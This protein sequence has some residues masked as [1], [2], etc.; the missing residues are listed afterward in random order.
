VLVRAAVEDAAGSTSHA[1]KHALKKTGHATKHVARST[2]D[3][4]DDAATVSEDSGANTFNVLVN[5]TDADGDSL[6]VTGVT[7]GTHG[8]VVNNGSSVS[9]TPNANYFGTDSFTYTISDGHGG[10]DGGTMMSPS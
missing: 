8:A 2:D 5:D 10:T 6:T 4:V 7:Q 9:Y 1:T 3:A